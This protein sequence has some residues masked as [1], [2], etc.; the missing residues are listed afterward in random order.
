MAGRLSSARRLR[1]SLTGSRVA[2]A[3]ALG[4]AP[5]LEGRRPLS[6]PPPGAAPR[7]LEAAAASLP[8]ASRTLAARRT[9]L[10]T[11]AIRGVSPWARRSSATNC[12]TSSTAAT[13]TG[14]PSVSS[15][16]E[17]G[18]S[19]VRMESSSPAGASLPASGFAVT[20]TPVREARSNDRGTGVPGEPAAGVVV[21][22]GSVPAVRGEAYEPSYGGDAHCRRA[23][24]SASPSRID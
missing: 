5:P 11:S 24:Q 19:S 17:A 23:A 20:G 6:W 21:V 9:R 4:A 8:C 10:T 22:T 7:G 13:C 1:H 16:R 2:L 12:R 18:S 15:A 3:A 14:S